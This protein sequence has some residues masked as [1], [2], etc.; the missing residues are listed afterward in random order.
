MTGL[1]RNAD[2]VVMTSYAPLMAHAEG[3][4]WTPDLIWFDNLQAYGTANYYVQKLYANHAGTDL[5]RITHDGAPLTG[6]DSLYAS[7]VKDT[8]RGELYVKVVNTSDRSRP[9]SIQI[10]GARPAAT[11]MA[12][13]LAGYA[14]DAVNSFAEPQK[15]APVAHEVTVRRGVLRAEVPPRAFVVYKVNIQ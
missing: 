15:I 2:L 6:Q 14:P 5:L 13:T 4:Q 7:A 9:L 1:E 3:W 10:A 11:A 12:L 8:D